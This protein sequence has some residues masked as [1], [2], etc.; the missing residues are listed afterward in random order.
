MVE[1]NNTSSDV[2]T[3]LLVTSAINDQTIG[4]ANDSQKSIKDLSKVADKE[5]VNN[6]HI[7]IEDE[8]KEAEVSILTDS[9]V[10][11]PPAEK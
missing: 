1:A 4:S 5:E 10:D 9:S 3:E 11:Y 7:A 2:Q 6:S 8:R